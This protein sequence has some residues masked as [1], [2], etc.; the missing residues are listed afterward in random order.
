MINLSKL[1]TAVVICSLL[2]GC[3][4]S[5]EQHQQVATTQDTTKKDWALVIHGGAGTISKKMPDSIKQAYRQ[6]LDEALSIGEGILEEGGAA[7]D[8]VEEVINYL[9]DNPQFN[10][11]KGAVFT[12]DGSHELDAAMMV[13]NSRKAGA[14]TGVKTV[15][16]PISLAR[17]V[18][19]NSKHIMFAS[20]GGEKY[21]DKMGVERVNQ[22][23]F[24]TERRYKAWRRA[25]K[26]GEEQSSVLETE[27]DRTLFYDQDK[28]GT[29]GCVALDTDGQL[30]AGTSTG[31]MTNKMYGRVGDV[32]IIGSGTYASDEV[33]VSMTG[34]GERIMEAVSGHTVSSYMKYKPATLQEAGRYL[35][36]DV[37]APG[38]AGMISVDKYGNMLMDMNTKGMF[39][40]QSDSEGNRKVA[41]WED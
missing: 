12:H 3:Q 7:T 5:S 41:I 6:D 2:V 31:G 17:L 13:G 36:Q 33:A 32:P 34:W 29:V 28:Y 11:G 8:A 14:I 27:E 35:L 18:M 21:A 19:E 39:R 1:V 10:A 22:D 38:E 24:Y 40:G 26:E 25:I 37:L 9:E 23:Y 20:E 15:K 4:E 16:N 30:V